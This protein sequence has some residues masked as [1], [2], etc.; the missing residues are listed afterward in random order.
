MKVVHVCTIPTGAAYRLHRGLQR[1]G[2]DSTMFVADIQ[3]DLND[4]SVKVFKPPRRFR[5]RVRRRLRRMQIARSFARYRGT[6]PARAGYFFD[7]RSPH[8][9]DMFAQ[10]PDCD[11]IHLHTMLELVDFQEFF[12]YA[13]RRAPIVRT[14]HDMSFFTGG[15]HY[16]WGC[17][18]FTECCGVCPQLGSRDGEDLS[19]QV[20]RRK[21]AALSAVPPSRL[22]VIVP[23][24]WM[25]DM[26]K[27]S[28]LLGKFPITVI[29][30]SLD[31]ERFRMRD[32]R[33]ARDTLGV[34]QHARVILF[35]A[36]PIGRP[37]KGFALL[38]EALRGLSQRSNPFLLSAGSG[39]PPTEVPIPHLHLGLVNE[40]FLSL[41]YSAADVLVVP[42]ILDNFPQ[43][44]LEAMACGVPVA[45]FAVG[46]IPEI[47]RESVTGL[48]A[49]ARNVEA[50]RL[51]IQAILEDTA[52]HA[53]LSANC[54]RIAVEEYALEV[55]A[56]RHRVL[57]ETIRNGA[58]LA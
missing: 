48:L 8:G 50:L 3:A 9:A 34:P 36:S 24:Q 21:H 19:R 18:R 51:V 27:G 20:W 41:V 5:S 38:A 31:T 1:L 45:A 22:H 44:A 47:V 54:R 28:S 23:S 32:Q 46:G 4:P 52:R 10:L 7:D 29:P 13:P 12:R 26:A 15:C 53:Q 43:V 16:D 25:A 11:I 37:E 56:Q 58:A 30:L 55:Q 2:L 6:R 42:S 49:P 39:Q 40:R 35:L 14:L 17:G 33:A 57:Y